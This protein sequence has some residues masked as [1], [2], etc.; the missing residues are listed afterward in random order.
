MK[1]NLF[2]FLLALLMS[3]AVNVAMAY[4][5]KVGSIY[6]NLNTSNKTAE[7]TYGASTNNSYSGGI[8]I[9]TSVSYNN[10]PY[11]VTRIA[12]SAFFKCTGLTSVYIPSSITSISQDA[13]YGC[14]GLTSV[15]IPASVYYIGYRAFFECTNLASISIPSSITIIDEFAF[16]GTPW[17]ESWLA[18]QQNGPCYINT[19]LYTYKGT[20]P[21]NT[22]IAVKDGTT[23]IGGG[24]FKDCSN[25]VSVEIPQSVTRICEHAFTRTGL[26]EITLPTSILSL[27]LGAFSNC[28]NLTSVTLSEG[29]ERVTGEAFVNCTNLTTVTLPSTITLLSSNAFRNCNNLSTVKVGMRTPIAIG[30]EVFTNRFVATLIVPRGCKAAYQAAEYWGDFKEIKEENNMQDGEVFTA[31]TEEGVEMKFMVISATDKTCTVSGGLDEDECGLPA[32][33]TQYAGEITIPSE[34]KGLKV[35]SIGLMAFEYCENITSAY[36]S[37]GIEEIDVYG[38]GNCEKLT[39]VRLPESLKHIER[40]AFMYCPS[41]ESINIPKNVSYLG[42]DSEWE[43]HCLEFTPSL[44]SISVDKDNAYYDS[45]DN[46]NAIISKATNTLIVGCKNTI[47]PNSVT[48][49]GRGAFYDCEDL[50][51]IQIPESVTSIMENAF[52]GCKSLTTITIPKNVTSLG[53]NFI[54]SCDRLTTIYSMIESPFDV[55]NKVFNA[56][57][58]RYYREATLYVPKGTKVLYQNA[59]G[60][61][62]FQNIQEI[63]GSEPIEEDTDISQLDNV[64]YLETTEVHAGTKDTLSFRMKNSAAIRAFQ[65]DL[66]LPEGITAAK[67]S[68]GKIIGALSNGRLPE[69]DELKL[70]IQEQANGSIRFQCNS[71]YDETFTGNEGVILTLTVNIADDVV[72]SEYPVVMKDMCLTEIDTS[73]YYEHSYIKTTLKGPGCATPT[74]AYSGGKLKFSCETEGVQFVSTITD[75]DIKSYDTEEVE[76]SVTYTISVYATKAGYENSEVAT[77]TLCWIDVEPQKEGITDEDAVTEV[78]ALPVLIQTQGSTITIQGAEEGTPISVYSVNGMLQSSAI[79]DEGSTTLST[80]LQP[81][82]VAIVKIGEKSVKVMIK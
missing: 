5:A 4:D 50:N 58:D 61:K 35:K 47:I 23:C 49:I 40:G 13:F 44:A 48:T 70:T 6:Y 80:S 51:S 28:S 2:S 36:I 15:T 17:R 22:S 57:E 43:Y 11:K 77:A 29:L 26:K 19:V 66:Y 72:N 59:G 46:C 75:D 52:M 64:I 3:M 71:E 62:N 65:F 53:K 31:L 30:S 41:L 1:H 8:S 9:P 73:K 60:W 55:D 67:N 79:A 78:K 20:M 38:F 18:S 27:G 42:E 34:V 63:G 81:G 54:Y 32:I 14:T 21:P 16:E 68:K 39:S 7:V 82:S 56:D 74:I 69:D 37:D 33:D 76:L 24:A 12:S 10:V 45:R 25:L